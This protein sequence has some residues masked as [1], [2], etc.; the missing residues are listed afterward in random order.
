MERIKDPKKQWKYNETDLKEA[1]FRDDYIKMYEDCFEHCNEIPWTI[2]P[3]DQ[4][5]FKEYLV[6][7]TVCNLLKSLKLEFPSLKT[8][9]GKLS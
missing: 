8:N 7:S 5:W 6:A 4:N 1:E 9:T 3:A 2:V